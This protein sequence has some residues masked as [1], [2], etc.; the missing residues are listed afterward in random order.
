[1]TATACVIVL[2]ALDDY[3]CL[4]SY[5]SYPASVLKRRTADSSKKE[6]VLADLNPGPQLF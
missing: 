3:G 6:F 5:N 4:G 2:F 1:M